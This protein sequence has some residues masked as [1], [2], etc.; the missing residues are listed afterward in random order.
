M[1]SSILHTLTPVLCSPRQ[2]MHQGW[3]GWFS[4]LDSHIPVHARVR[5]RRDGKR[6]HHV[7][8]SF[9]GLALTQAQERRMHHRQRLQARGLLGIILFLTLLGAMGASLR[10]PRSQQAFHLSPALAATASSGAFPQAGVDGVPASGEQLTI[11]SSV[12]PTTI[13]SGSGPVIISKKWVTKG[14]SNNPWVGGPYQPTT[15]KP[16]E[17][18]V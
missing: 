18:I 9:R 13:R 1:T 6:N 15:F 3:C 7:L 11:R 4:C 8:G 10:P 16:G 2:S 14:T 17:R 12:V 5:R